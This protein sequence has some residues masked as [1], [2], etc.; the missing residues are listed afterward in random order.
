VTLR[1][2]ESGDH[3]EISAREVHP[4]A[5][6]GQAWIAH[7]ELTVLAS[8]AGAAQQAW[9]LLGD[10]EVSIAARAGV[11]HHVR[12]LLI[13]TRDAWT[14][15]EHLIH[16]GHATTVRFPDEAFA[17]LRTAHPS[18][19]RLRGRVVVLRSVE[20]PIAVDDLPAVFA[21]V[22]QRGRRLEVARWSAAT[23]MFELPPPDVTPLAQHADDRS[24]GPLDWLEGADLGSCACDAVSAVLDLGSLGSVDCVPDC[25][26]GCL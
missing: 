7:S 13:A 17:V 10:L 21:A 23:T 14:E 3:V 24:C 1:G 8:S 18:A 16:R 9:T 6:P 20:D 5:G 26:P 2:T 15:G 12:S 25:D 4:P 22:V 19:R 11:L